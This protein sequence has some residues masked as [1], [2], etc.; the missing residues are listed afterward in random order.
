MRPLYVPAPRAL[1]VVGMRALG[2]LHLSLAGSYSSTTEMSEATPRNAAPTRPPITS[3][4][5]CTAPAAAWLRGVGIGLR[6]RQV[7]VAG[8]YSSPVPNTPCGTV[9][10]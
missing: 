1:R 4:W 5:R 9:G 3:L 2:A 10:I 6:A 8:S 7:F